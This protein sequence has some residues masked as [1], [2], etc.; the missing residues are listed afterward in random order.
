MA[1]IFSIMVADMFAVFTGIEFVLELEELSHKC[2]VGIELGE[3]ERFG[4]LKY[5]GDQD[6]ATVMH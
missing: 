2:E 6:R 4:G 5:S 3:V 1:V